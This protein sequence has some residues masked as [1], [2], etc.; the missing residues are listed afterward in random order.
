MFAILQ[1]SEVLGKGKKQVD[2]LIALVIGLI[3]ISFGYAVS[4]INNLIPFLAVGLVILLVF[5]LLFGTLY[6]QGEFNLHKGVKIGIG[7]VIAIAVIIAVLVF[8]GVWDTIL[9]AFSGD[10]G[11]SWITNI[12]FLLIVVGVVAAVAW[13]GGSG[14]KK[15]S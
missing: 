14:D 15:G 5:M 7:I 13:G 2:A 11:S 12:V 1:K 3:V 8:S 9:E 6:K 4:I 10:S